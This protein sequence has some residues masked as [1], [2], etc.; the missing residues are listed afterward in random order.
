MIKVKVL[1]GVAVA[2][3]M[4]M[5]AGAN[6]TPAPREG[7]SVKGTVK[8]TTR[9]G[10]VKKIRMTADPKCAAMHSSAPK[11]ENV[12]ATKD[13][14]TRWAFVYVKKGASA[15]KTPDKAV[16]INQKGCQYHPH[17]FGLQTGQKLKI[18]N[19]NTLD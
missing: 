5:P 2:A 10:R 11:M 7:S 18:K 1:L 4:C 16:V 17:V 8:I 9:I 13:G 3:M 19:L 15:T 6:E 14:L 12:V